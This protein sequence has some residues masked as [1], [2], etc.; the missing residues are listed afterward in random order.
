MSAIRIEKGLA[1]QDII[2]ALYDILDELTFPKEARVYLLDQLANV[3]HRL[4]TGGSEIIQSSALLGAFKVRGR[5]Q[6]VIPAFL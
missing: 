2:Q 3:E 4:S 1:L 5:L 6:T